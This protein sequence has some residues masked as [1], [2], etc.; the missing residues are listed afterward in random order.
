MDTTRLQL[1][2]ATTIASASLLL[3]V[4]LSVMY[5]RAAKKLV[6]TRTSSG[7][8]RLDDAETIRTMIRHEN[9]LVN[10]RLTWLLTVEGLLLAGISFAW[11]KHLANELVF[12]FAVIGIIA[13]GS[14]LIVLDAAHYAIMHLGAWWD[15][16]KPTAYA[17]PDVLGFRGHHYI[18]GFLAAWRLIPPAFTVV[19]LLGEGKVK[20]DEKVMRK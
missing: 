19:W 3:W 15:Q 7:S 18:L 11:D 16:N 9:D 4:V 10:H 8:A 13:A 6:T 14:A 5:F 17:G 20:L 1:A 12:L 2:I